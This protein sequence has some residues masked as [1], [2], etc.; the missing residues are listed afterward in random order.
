MSDMKT[1]TSSEFRVKYQQLQEPHE[2]TVL[3]RV[4]GEWKPRDPQPYSVPDWDAPMK[5][6][7]RPVPKLGGRKKNDRSRKPA[8][9]D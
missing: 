8:A 5:L 1:I 9:S 6:E 4:I 2:V 3:G 7:F